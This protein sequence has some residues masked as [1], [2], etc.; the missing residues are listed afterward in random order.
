MD[1][2]AAP[3]RRLPWTIP[4]LLVIWVLVE[5]VDFFHD[6]Q[7]RFGRP[8]GIEFTVAEVLSFIYAFLIVALV[9][10][11]LIRGLRFPW[12]IALVWQGLRGG[13]GVVNFVAND[14]PFDWFFGTNGIPLYGITIPIVTAL[15]SFVLLLLPT[16]QR[17]VRKT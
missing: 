5:L 13:F 7:D 15:V 10:Y 6:R 4:T 2:P 16:T 1:A 14:Y 8:E 12:L 11:G 17:W 9:G 3:P